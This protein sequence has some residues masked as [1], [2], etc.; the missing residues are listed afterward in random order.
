[1][2]ENVHGD[3]VEKTK[4]YKHINISKKYFVSLNLIYLLPKNMYL[5]MSLVNSYTM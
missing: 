1:M 4:Y 5:H 2:R 3:H